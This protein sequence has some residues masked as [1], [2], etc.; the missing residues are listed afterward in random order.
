M[1]T[2]P[3]GKSAVGNPTGRWQRLRLRVAP[4]GP[5]LSGRT[6]LAFLALLLVQAAG[7]VVIHQNLDR[8]AHTQLADRLSLAE[9]VWQRLLDQRAAR[10]SQGATALAA[11][12]PWAKR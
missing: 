9:R 2:G 1:S 8:N 10:L 11:D 12:H 3:T 5:R 4:N 7:F 6:V